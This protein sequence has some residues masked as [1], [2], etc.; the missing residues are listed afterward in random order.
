[1]RYYFGN[2]LELE[3]LDNKYKTWTD[4]YSW[5]IERKKYNEK[6]FKE[7]INSTKIQSI[8]KMYKARKKYLKDLEYYEINHN[9]TGIR[10]L[11]ELIL[12]F[13]GEDEI[14]ECINCED[15]IILI[16]DEDKYETHTKGD[17]ICYDCVEDTN[18]VS[19]DKCGYMEHIDEAHFCDNC[20]DWNS[21]ECCNYLWISCLDKGY[22]E[23]CAD[24]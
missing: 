4:I 2:D 14:V 19:C 13:V 24:G 11:D 21:N 5:E 7:Y 6:F 23:R 9:F 8:W 16:E 10:D 3:L 15:K 1:M 18:W 17:Y 22:C 20:Q 12:D